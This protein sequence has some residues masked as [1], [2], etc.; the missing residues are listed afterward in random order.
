MKIDIEKSHGMTTIN[1][2]GNLDYITAPELDELITKEATTSDKIVL[3]M[4]GVDYISSA[5]LRSILNADELMQK[6][7]GIKLT[8]VNSNVRYILE[9]TGFDRILDIE[10]KS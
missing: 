8:N 6:K 3:N 9:M 5:G 2:V 1:I 10:Y 4:D 7:E